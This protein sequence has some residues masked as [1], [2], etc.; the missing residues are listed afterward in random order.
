[1]RYVGKDLKVFRDA[2][3]FLAVYI[4]QPDGELVV[5]DPDSDEKGL[6]FGIYGK[7]DNYDARTRDYFKG[8][9]KA[10]GLYVTPSYLDLTN[11]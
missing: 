9:V 5:T 10:N 11:Y 4:A 6:N 7:A 2:G 8:A 1:M 3:G